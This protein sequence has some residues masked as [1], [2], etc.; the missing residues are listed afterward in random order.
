M[1][2]RH[3]GDGARFDCQI[4]YLRESKRLGTAGALSLLPAPPK[5]PFFVVNADIVTKVD[6]ADMLATHEN[7]AAVAT[8]AVP[9]V[10]VSIPFGVIEE[11][12]GLISAIT[13]EAR[14]SLARAAPACTC[15]RLTCSAF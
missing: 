15:C 11:N 10:R 6:Y 2:E 7:S 8:M 14:A 12:A 5:S 1:I 9:R 4:T 3:F 13:E